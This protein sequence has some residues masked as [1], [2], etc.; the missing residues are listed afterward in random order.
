MKAR[1]RVLCVTVV[2]ATLG[3]S[4]ALGQ[5]YRVTKIGGPEVAA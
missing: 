1:G 3:C 5:G 4:H 2:C